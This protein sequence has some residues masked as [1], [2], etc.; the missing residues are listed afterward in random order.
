MGHTIRKSAGRKSGQ[1][2]REAG[3]LLSP[4]PSSFPLLVQSVG[5]GFLH[6]LTQAGRIDQFHG[7]TLA[8]FVDEPV[9]FGS[10]GFSVRMSSFHNSRVYRPKIRRLFHLASRLRYVYQIVTVFMPYLNRITPLRYQRIKR[11]PRGAF[12]MGVTTGSYSEMQRTENP[13]VRT[14]FPAGTIWFSETRR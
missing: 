13:F 4:L 1:S 11:P 12:P 9:Q 14:P 6:D 2:P 5:D 3:A 10:P 7:F 8:Y